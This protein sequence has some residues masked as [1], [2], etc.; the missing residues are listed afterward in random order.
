[1]T[2]DLTTTGDAETITAERPVFRRTIGEVEV[3][4]GDGLGDGD[5]AKVDDDGV[6]VR[7]SSSIRYFRKRN[8]IF[9]SKRNC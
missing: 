3:V 5:G 7:A 9:N 1:M 2:L 8:K 6:R 4:V